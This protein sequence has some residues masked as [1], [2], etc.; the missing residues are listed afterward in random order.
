MGHGKD[1]SLSAVMRHQHSAG[2]ALFGLVAPVA[3]SCPC[4]LAMMQQGIAQHQVPQGRI[5]LHGRTECVRAQAEGRALALRHRLHIISRLTEQNRQVDH[6]FPPH[7]AHLG[8]VATV[9][10]GQHGRSAGFQEVHRRDG[11]LRLMQI[12]VE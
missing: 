2:E 11:S 10:L 1:V 7:E 5:I 4:C 12:L 9:H 8:G 6:A 3:G